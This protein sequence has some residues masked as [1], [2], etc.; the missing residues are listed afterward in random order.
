VI[1][2]I[3]PV[4]NESAILAG[5]LKRLMPE[6]NE[7][8]L[9]IVDGGSQDATRDIAQPFGRLIESAKGMGTQLNAGARVAR[10][11][12]LFFL[13][14]D[15]IPQEGALQA[16]QEKMQ[17]E[18]IA[19][20]GLTQ[21]IEARGLFWRLIETSGNIRARRS[22][23]FYGDQGIFVRKCVFEEL[24]GLK[25]AGFL[26]DLDFAKRLSRNKHVAML[27]NRIFCSPRRW[28]NQGISKTLFSNW[29]IRGAL[30][31]GVSPRKLRFL[32][33]EV[34]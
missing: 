26:D 19:G 16:I 13:H 25:E 3:I 29:I 11:D 20:G 24:N 8:E 10:G 7:H 12:I 2:V 1:S 31:M 28:K 18:R 34:R 9:I 15:S 5:R 4:L 23:V 33:P 32:Y 27:K 14:A 17:D 30:R 22:G 6:L 21:R